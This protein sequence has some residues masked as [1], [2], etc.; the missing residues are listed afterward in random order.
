MENNLIL[1]LSSCFLPKLIESDH[2]VAVG[3]H[4]PFG[5]SC[6]PTGKRQ[7]HQIFVNVEKR[8]NELVREPGA[9]HGMP[10]GCAPFSSRCIH[11]YGCRVESGLVQQ[12]SNL[13][14]ANP[15]TRMANPVHILQ[16]S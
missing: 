9:H 8:L 11:H 3:D 7:S 6:R 2:E 1:M 14:S 12:G 5:R 4:G 13:R 16:L 15:Q 10:L